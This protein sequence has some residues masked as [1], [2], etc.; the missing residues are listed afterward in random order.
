MEAAQPS[1][2]PPLPILPTARS[3][4]IRHLLSDPAPRDDKMR[5]RLEFL[6]C[7]RACKGAG[8]N[9][10]KL[11]VVMG[12]SRNGCKASAL[13]RSPLQS[14]STK[15]HST[16]EVLPV[17]SALPPSYSVN[18]PQECSRCCLALMLQHSS[19]SL[20]SRSCLLVSSLL[21]PEHL[22]VSNALY[23]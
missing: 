8:I 19:K 9:S 15:S 1:G 3:D 20:S 16:D 14:C 12:A 22:P 4:G 18:P 21:H 13:G 10:T 23:N 17:M 11:L 7:C 6:E 2:F 5:A